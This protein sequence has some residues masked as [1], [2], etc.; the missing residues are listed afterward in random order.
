M[1]VMRSQ[2]GAGSTGNWVKGHSCHSGEV[3]GCVLFVVY[4][5]EGIK[6][7]EN[8]KQQTIPAVAQFLLDAFSEIGGENSKECVIWRKK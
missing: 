1:G 3:S 4:K 7:G 6:G 8:S 2:K 5:S